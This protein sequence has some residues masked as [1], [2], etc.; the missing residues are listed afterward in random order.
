MKK[1]T[2]VKAIRHK[3]LECQA[4]RYSLVRNCEEKGCPLHRFRLGRNP[5]HS[6]CIPKSGDSKSG[7]IAG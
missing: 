5:N 3:C 6:G 4:N 7:K 2:P 1:L